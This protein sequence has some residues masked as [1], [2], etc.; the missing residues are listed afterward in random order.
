[1]EFVRSRSGVGRWLTAAA[2]VAIVLVTAI[3]MPGESGS[4]ATKCSP[5]AI[6]CGELVAVDFLLNVLLYIPLGVGLG[7]LRGWAWAWIP[8]A[9][10][11]AIETL[12]VTALHGR[13][14]S[15][16]DVISN[17]LGGTLGIVIA[18]RWAGLRRAV[19]Q[20]PDRVLVVAST[21]VCL[22][23]A[24]A[25]VLLRPIY[26]ASEWYGQWAPYLGSFD[27]FPGRLYSAEFAGVAVKSGR[28]EEVDPLRA[29]A[30]KYGPGVRAQIEAPPI[31]T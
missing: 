12:Q 21:T 11:V 9:L 30:A 28:I 31:P 13:D 16:R 19:S 5:L 17:G 25:A 7:L 6:L 10:S 18:T 26:P 3:P 2:L 22:T 24:L 14:A 8:F 29:A 23:F 1:M 15:L 20:T 27:H 4:A